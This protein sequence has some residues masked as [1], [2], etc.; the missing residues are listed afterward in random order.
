M[1][2]ATLI[3]Q[4]AR[5]TLMVVD[6]VFLGNNRVSAEGLGV[7]LGVSRK[8]L[9]LETTEK[10]YIGGL[11]RW[12]PPHQLKPGISATYAGSGLYLC[13]PFVSPVSPCP[14]GR[15]GSK[16]FRVQ[17]PGIARS[18]AQKPCWWRGPWQLWQ[19][20]VQQRSLWQIPC[21]VLCPGTGEHH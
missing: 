3:H 9:N 13:F 15:P 5:I 1:V 21:Y 10:Q 12:T 16:V 2:L 6:F 7:F 14:A 18:I 8:N 11:V 17:L 4:T 20:D 19:R